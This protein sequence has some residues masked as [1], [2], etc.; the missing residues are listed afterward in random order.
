MAHSQEMIKYQGVARA[1]F[2][3]GIRERAKV[4]LVRCVLWVIESMLK[5]R[6]S[7]KAAVNR[8]E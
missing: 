1:V 6:V 5:H 3:G 2:K 8:T 4:V 7:E